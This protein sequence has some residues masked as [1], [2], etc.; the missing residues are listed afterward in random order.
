MKLYVDMFDIKEF[1]LQCTE[2][3]D[4]VFSLYIVASLD[5]TY[6]NSCKSLRIHISFLE[7]VDRPIYSD[8]LA[9]LAMHFC[10]VLLQ[11]II[12]PQIMITFLFTERRCALPAQSASA[13][14]LRRTFSRF[15]GKPKH[16]VPFGYLNMR[17][18]PV[19]WI[20]LGFG[21]CVLRKCVHLDKQLTNWL[22]V[23][24]FRSISYFAVST[25][26]HLCNSF[27]LSP[28]LLEPAFNFSFYFLLEWHSRIF[29]WKYNQILT[30]NY[31]F[32]QKIFSCTGVFRLVVLTKL[33]S[34][35]SEHLKIFWYE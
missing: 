4:P 8:S 10:L 12:E 31:S 21:T 1:L 11:P 30:L 27:F 9:D 18:F 34:D 33:R 24:H 26:L 16:F 13:C 29:L 35:F 25:F 5:C 17:F 22:S 7:A 2:Y 6:P 20:G 14:A 28:L 32:A 15:R 19:H 3:I 23:R